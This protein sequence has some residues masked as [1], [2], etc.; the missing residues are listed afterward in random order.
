[1]S[2]VLATLDGAREA[3]WAVLARE[4]ASG[5]LAALATA[6]TAGGGAA[7]MVV[8]R[9]SDAK[10]GTLEIWTNG[11]SEKLREIAAETRGELL[12]WQAENSLQIRASVTLSARKG[13]QSYWATLGDG[14]Q[15]NYA[16]APVPGEQIDTPEALSPEPDPDLF[17]V[18]T[19]HVQAIDI[20]SLTHRPHR[21]AI[22][23]DT[24]A[25]WVAP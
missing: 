16:R 24:G 19:A 17:T 1:M 15:L 6:R 9:G 12:F 25:R 5:G 23:D 4:A 11:A 14:S 10:A 3:A 22:I 2:D 20:V 21:R 8:L 18:L 7:R 13:D